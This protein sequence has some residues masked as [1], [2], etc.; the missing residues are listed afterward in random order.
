VDLPAEPTARLIETTFK[1]SRRPF[2]REQVPT[3]I[4]PI[5]DVITRASIFDSDLPWHPVQIF[6][7]RWLHT[8]T[9][10][11]ESVVDAAARC[12]DSRHDPLQPPHAR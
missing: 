1:R 7:Q 12:H 5:D 2:A 8:I 10:P 6:S 4:T 9:L 11:T 3:V